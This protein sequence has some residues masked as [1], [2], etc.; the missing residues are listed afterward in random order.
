M[1]TIEVSD[2][3]FEFLKSCQDE[4]ITQDNR[5]TA[6]PIYGF[7]SKEKNYHNSEGD[8]FVVLDRD[9]EMICDSSNEDYLVTLGKYVSD[10]LY[11]NREKANPFLDFLESNLDKDIADIQ[12]YIENEDFDNVEKEIVSC[13]TDSLDNWELEDLAESVFDWEI[14]WYSFEDKVYRESFSIFESDAENH[15]KSNRHNMPKDVW[16]Y[17]FSN[18]RTP[19][20]NKLKDIL[21]SEIKF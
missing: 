17:A 6:N 5:C 3:V 9:S 19:K 2:E 15:L 16:S 7:M 11:E 18:Y 12:E 21:K 20:M 4:L 8:N 14:V 13:F 10:N 1:K